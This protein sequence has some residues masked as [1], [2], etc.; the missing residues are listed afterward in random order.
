MKCFYHYDKD[1]AALCSEC[2]HPLC[3]DCLIDLKGVIYCRDCL[4]KAIAPNALQKDKAV[5]KSK[6]PLK[7]SA[8]ATW[9]SILPGLGLIYLELYLKGIAIFTVFI[10]L[11]MVF[12]GDPLCPIVCIAFW[13]FQ[14]VYA[15]QEAK[16]IN[17]RW[18][19]IKEVREEKESASLVWG[20]LVILFGLIF[21]I[22]NF[23]FDLTWLYRFWPLL[24]IGI[25]VQLIW[26]SFKNSQASS[27]HP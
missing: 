4:E 20:G 19:N 17:R 11:M 18:L 21:L 22:H 2:N 16:R 10:G 7:S 1:L 26:N 3:Q 8:T 5:P 12:K 23:G 15:N 25:G 27:D 24:I 6:K 14:L 13:L 9:L